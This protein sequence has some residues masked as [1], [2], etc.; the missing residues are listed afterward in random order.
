MELT[1][2]KQVRNKSRKTFIMVI[3]AFILPVLIAKLALEFN[4]LE[5]GVTNKGELISSS[6]RVE[7]FGVEM[8]SLAKEK[9]WLMLYV[10]PKDC[11]NLCQ[12]VLHGINNTYVALGKEMPRVTPTALYQ[13]PLTSEA[14]ASI[15]AH[16]WH[17]EQA[18]QKALNNAQQSKLY[19]VDPLGNA[20]MSH[21]L[22]MATADIP[23]FGK[24][25]VA[26]MKKLLKYSKV[27]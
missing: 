7:D 13:K 8:A 21:N 5:Y 19:I 16:D 4:W 6:M 1:D 23:P 25:V 24:A 18:S 27:G 2:N 9:Q 10:L 17:I 11:E 22:P 26:D 14:L 3:I 12:Q 20:F 15:R